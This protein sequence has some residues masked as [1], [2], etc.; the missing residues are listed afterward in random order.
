MRVL[1]V[2]FLYGFI[3]LLVAAVQKYTFENRYKK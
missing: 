2:L 3:A 1:A